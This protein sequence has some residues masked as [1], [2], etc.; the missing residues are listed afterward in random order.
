MS[1]DAF[2]IAIDGPAA[3]G[4]GTISTRVAAHF[5]VAHLV[6][7]LLYRAGGRRVLDGSE[8]L[9]AARGLQAADLARDDLRLP[10][11]SQAASEVAADPDVRAALVA[12][13]R[14]FARRPG[15]A[16]LDGR[17]IGTV[18]CPDAEVKLFVTASAEVRADRRFR[19]LTDKG[20]STSYDAVLADQRERDA[21]DS[22]RTD[23]PLA[24]APDAIRI[25][26][27]AMTIEQAVARAIHEVDRKR[28]GEG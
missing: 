12:F 27:S 14:D 20:H 7:G 9:D 8:A 18:I 15:G 6:T 25:D 3:A 17:D 19:E 5:G 28:T 16:V 4:M 26:T 23:A 13:Q 1:K 11:V 21:R 24:E 2:T 10:D 22:G